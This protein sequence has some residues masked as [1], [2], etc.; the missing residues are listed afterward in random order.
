MNDGCQVA[1]IER[2]LRQPASEGASNRQL[3]EAAPVEACLMTSVCD[4]RASA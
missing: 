4:W 2:F 1:A 3:A